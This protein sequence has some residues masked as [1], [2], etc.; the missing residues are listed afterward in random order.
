[1]KDFLVPSENSKE[2]FYQFY[3]EDIIKSCK[4]KNYNYSYKIN[5]NTINSENK[6][7]CEKCNKLF[8][9]PGNLKVHVITVHEHYRPFK[10]TFPNCTKVY[11]SGSQLIIHER[12]HTGVK[13]F[14]CKICQKLFHRKQNL[15]LHLKVHFK[16]TFE[17]LLCA[18]KFN[19]NKA[20][21]KH[22]NINKNKKFCC[23]ICNKHF[24]NI[25]KSKKH[26]ENHTKEYGFKCKFENCGKLTL[27]QKKYG[28]PL[29]K[30]YEKYRSFNRK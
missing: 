2:S 25:S 23:N 7:L 1:M 19:S 22:I 26:M 18:K 16:K 15:K 8:S 6:L 24:S 10:C 3:Q 12:T 21:E 20:L 27:K 5:S 13:P 14:A 4:K 29:F 30:S 11:A 28:K 9:T 17:C